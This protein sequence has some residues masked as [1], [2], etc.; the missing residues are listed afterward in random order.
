MIT[1]PANHVEILN[2]R[3]KA[4]DINEALI[5]AFWVHASDKDRSLFLLESAHQSFADLAD[6]LGYDIARRE[7][8]APQAAPADE[9]EA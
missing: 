4:C 3:S 2:G 5:A 7:A 8:A 1:L 6:A 9:V